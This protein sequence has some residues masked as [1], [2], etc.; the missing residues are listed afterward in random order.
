[1]GGEERRVQDF[2][3]ETPTERR[4]LEDP[5]VDGSSGVPRN[6]VRGKGGFNK[7]S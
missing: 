4:H 7:F 2:G 6:V 1:M 3:W 5:R